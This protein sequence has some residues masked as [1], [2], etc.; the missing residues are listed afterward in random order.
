VP[1]PEPLAGNR[2]G[3][4]AVAGHRGHV[5]VLGH[6]AAPSSASRSPAA[7]GPGHGAPP[8]RRISGSGP[9]SPARGL[10]SSPGFRSLRGSAPECH[11]RSAACRS[12]LLPS[13][14]SRAGAGSRADR[15][16]CV[17]FTVRP[18]M[19]RRA[20]GHALRPAGGGHGAGRPS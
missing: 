3:E 5:Q 11:L 7:A 15:Y 13:A 6:S 9:A 4:P 18:L 2:A 10:P 1:Q 17:A 14:R 8:G 16:A 20:G 19:G 12:R